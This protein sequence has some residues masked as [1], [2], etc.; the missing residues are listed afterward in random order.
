MKEEEEEETKQAALATTA[1]ITNTLIVGNR[2]GYLL[3]ENISE[4]KPIFAV[5]VATELCESE[6]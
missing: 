2:H 4:R 6:F 3:G 5:Q 1:R